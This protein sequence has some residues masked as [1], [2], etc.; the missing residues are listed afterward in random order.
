MVLDDLVSFALAHYVI[1]GLVMLC[2]GIALN[3]AFTCGS[4]LIQAI[5]HPKLN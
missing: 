4:D 3:L 5:R 1:V 2:V